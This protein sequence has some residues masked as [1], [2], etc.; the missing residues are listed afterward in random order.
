MNEKNQIHKDN[1][2]LYIDDSSLT[3]FIY[4]NN[5]FQNEYEIKTIEI[6]KNK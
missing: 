3:F 1:I 2:I 5:L 4:D 6:G